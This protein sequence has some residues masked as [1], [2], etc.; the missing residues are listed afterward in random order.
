MASNSWNAEELRI[1]RVQKNPNEVRVAN[2]ILGRTSIDPIRHAAD[3][4]TP[5]T[6]VRPFGSHVGPSAAW[7]LP[8][9]E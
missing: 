5:R 2:R 8:S 1:G 3:R 7:T 9:R 4:T 6:A